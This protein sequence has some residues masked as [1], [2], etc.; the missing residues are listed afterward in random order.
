AK[1]VLELALRE[2]LSLGHNYIG[3]EHILLG[4]VRENE[5]VA[6]RI[7]LDFDA[8]AEKIRDEV[9]RML[10]GRSS[11]RREGRVYVPQSPPLATEF[12]EELERIRS[13]KQTAIE[14]QQFEEAAR[15]R[16]RERLLQRKARELETVWEAREEIGR[17]TPVLRPAGVEARAAELEA[18]WRRSRLRQSVVIPVWAL[19]A[20]GALPLAVAVLLGR[21]VTMRRR[22]RRHLLRP[23][24][25]LPHSRS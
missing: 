3:T 11:E 5:G 20:A 15:L 18:R 13:E 4:L 10:T 16:H 25:R 17:P 8:D 6:A 24:T 12:V 7:L 1:K 14:A 23:P 9:L 19:L 22:P 2:A 21:L